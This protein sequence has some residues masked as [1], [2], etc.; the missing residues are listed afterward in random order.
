M[1]YYPFFD[2]NLK[3]WYQFSALKI[4]ILALKNQICG[5]IIVAQRETSL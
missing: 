3:V 4:D 1:I 2:V 5:D